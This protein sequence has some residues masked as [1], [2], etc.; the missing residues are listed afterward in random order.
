MNNKRLAGGALESADRIG[1]IGE[2]NGNTHAALSVSREMNVR[3]ISWLLQ[4]G[5]FGFL[6]QRLELSSL[7]WLA[8]TLCERKQTLLFVDGN[9]ENFDEL[10]QIPVSG[11]GVRWITPEIGHLPRGFR[12]PLAAGRVLAALGGANSLDAWRGC[13]EG[14]SITEEDLSALGDEKADVLIGHDAPLHL[15]SLDKF[16][17]DT[18]YRWP[19]SGRE[20]AAS[21]RRVFHEGFMKVR[22]LLY[23]GAQYHRFVDQTVRYAGEGPV[24]ETRVILLDDASVQG[25]RSQAI[26]H[27]DSLEIEHFIV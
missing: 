8:E 5:D 10:N 1:L 26:L 7:R 20:Y 27:I 11:D 13:W 14:E 18:K 24:F 3:G 16:L 23:V 12:T 2:L 25:S 15:P 17:A 21:G 22:P 4:A 6:N 19:T 9:H